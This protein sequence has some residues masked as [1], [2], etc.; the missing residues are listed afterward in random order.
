MGMATN[1]PPVAAM[2]AAADWGGES[3]LLLDACFYISRKKCN[4]MFFNLRQ[5]NANS[6]RNESNC[7]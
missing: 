2:G 1:A 7:F 6:F 3:Q 5:K 4:K